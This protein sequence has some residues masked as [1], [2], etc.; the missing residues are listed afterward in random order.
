MRLGDNE[1]EEP[2]ERLRIVLLR[3][4]ADSHGA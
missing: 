3:G 4:N 1:V 2:G